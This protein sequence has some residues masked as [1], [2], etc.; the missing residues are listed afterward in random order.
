MVGHYHRNGSFENKRVYNLGGS[1]KKRK[2]QF[3]GMSR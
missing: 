2:L 3:T 1:N